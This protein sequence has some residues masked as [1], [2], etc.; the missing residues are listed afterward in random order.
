[1]AEF[2]PL[3]AQ[4][5]VAAVVREALGAE[6]R[7]L[8]LLK[9]GQLSQAFAFGTDAGEFVVRFNADPVG[10]LR[11]RYAA[12][13]FASPALPIPRVIGSGAVDGLAFAITEFVPGGH[14]HSRPPGEYLRLL[15]LA[16]DALD[17]LHR[18]DPGEATGYGPW[19]GPGRGLY[20]TWRRFLEGA[21]EEETEGFFTGWHRLFDE[22]FLERDLYEAISRRMLALVEFCP[23]ERRILHGD[24]GFDNV[25]ADGERITGVLDWST[26]SYGDFVYDLARIDFFS[27]SD[28]VTDLLRRRYAATTPHYAERLACYRC[29]TGLG[30]LRFYAL[31]N[32]RPIYEW[33]KQQVAR[34]LAG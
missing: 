26:L 21:N 33:A 31:A 27:A 9:G 28:A 29:W 16:L 6:V 1:L 18:V 24:F 3:V 12:E 19:R 8:R 5:K 15:P 11:D 23:E 4:E 2:K 25:L 17:A 34:H 14:L 7:G 22:S 13:H 32:Q 10:F 30:A 20:P